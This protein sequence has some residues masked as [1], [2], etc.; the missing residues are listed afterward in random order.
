MKRRLGEADVLI[1][2]TRKTGERPAAPDTVPAAYRSF[3]FTPAANVTGLPAVHVPHVG[4]EEGTDPGLQCI[5]PR[6]A[7]ARLIALA[8]RLSPFREG[9]KNHG[10]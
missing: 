4:T 2:P 3:A 1:G 8:A 9:G 5:G 7:D 6:L 10:S